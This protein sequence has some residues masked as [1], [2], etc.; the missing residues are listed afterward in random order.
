[1][2]ISNTDLGP[3]FDLLKGDTNLCSPRNLNSEADTSL[4]KVASAIASRQAHRWAP[5]LPFYLMILNGCTTASCPDISTGPSELRPPV[6][7]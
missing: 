5:E 3:L 7:Y 6:D 4:Q 2:G 1:M